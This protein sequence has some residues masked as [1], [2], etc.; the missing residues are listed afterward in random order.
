MLEA[1]GMQHYETSNYARE[2]CRSPHNMAYW[3]GEDYVGIGP[4]AVSTING[5]RYSNTRDTDA[6]IRSTLENGLPLS[7]QEP[8]TAEDYRL[9]RIALMLRTNEGL[10][11]KYI[12]PESRP[13]LEQYR[14][15]G[16]ADISPEQRLIL[17][18]RGRLLVDA[19]AAELC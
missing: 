10:P 19:I 1:A 17:K 11:L 4:G 9:E 6:Y 12:L 7:E 15:L 16:L 13:L 8:V 18:G 2:G 3:K 14:E 5:I